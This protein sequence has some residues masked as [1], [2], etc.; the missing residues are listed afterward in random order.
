MKVRRHLRQ[1]LE[2]R[3]IPAEIS[4][5]VARDTAAAVD[6]VEAAVGLAARLRRRLSHTDDQVARRRIAGAL[7]RRGFDADIIN[8]VLDRAGFKELQP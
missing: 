6:P 4:E 8:E 5:R 7:S 1:K 2:A 3:R